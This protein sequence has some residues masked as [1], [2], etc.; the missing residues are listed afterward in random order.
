[1]DNWTWTN[2]GDVNFAEYGGILLRKTYSEEELQK[3]PNLDS[4]YDFVE[5]RE[6]EKDVY[7]LTFGEVDVDNYT[8]KNNQSIEKSEIPMDRARNI[9]EY[10]G[11]IQMCG[12]ECTEALTK[13]EVYV[14]LNEL[15]FKCE[16]EELKEITEPEELFDLIDDFL[17]D[18]GYEIPQSQRNMLLEIILEEKNAPMTEKDYEKLNTAE[19]LV[20]ALD[21]E[22]GQTRYQDYLKEQSENILVGTPVI[23]DTKVSKSGIDYTLYCGEETMNNFIDHTEAEVSV[24]E[25]IANAVEA[26]VAVTVTASGN[27][28]AVLLLD[29]DKYPV[30]LSENEQSGLRARLDEALE[31]RGLPSIDETFAKAMETINRGE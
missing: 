9:I 29:D 26:R 10:Y 6:G 5:L 15:G 23:T 12:G 31:S 7:Y 13:Q 18:C 20:N 19:L 14:R 17:C 25:L 27:L 8:Y 22:M 2:Y 24:E 28:S 3:Y 1:M 30:N 21:A 4:Y 11:G 16:N